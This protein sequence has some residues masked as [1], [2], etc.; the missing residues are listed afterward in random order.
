MIW[1]QL[2]KTKVTK[3]EYQQNAICGLY[4]IVALGVLAWAIKY[5]T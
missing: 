4:I 3:E 1:K 5:F 2:P